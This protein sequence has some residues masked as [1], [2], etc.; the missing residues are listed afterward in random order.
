MPKP[1]AEQLEAAYFKVRQEQ[2]AS[3]LGELMQLARLLHLNYTAPLTASFGTTYNMTTAEYIASLNLQGVPDQSGSFLREQ[4]ALTDQLLYHVFSHRAG[5]AIEL[6]ELQMPTPMFSDA[7][8]DAIIGCLRDR[9]E[10]V[11]EA[12]ALLEQLDRA[13][14]Q[15]A[16]VPGLGE[17]VERYRMLVTGTAH[18]LQRREATWSRVL[19]SGAA[20]GAGA[21]VFA[22]PWLAAPLAAEA[23]TG[24]LSRLLATNLVERTMLGSSVDRL[25][26]RVYKTVKS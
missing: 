15:D 1:L 25:L 8:V 12:G 13:S 21:L 22:L 24:R 10:Q 26:F 17:L 7:S 19:R 20:V 14:L 5:S 3:D 2:R 11:R 18:E 23:A 6:G 4:S 16:T 9:A